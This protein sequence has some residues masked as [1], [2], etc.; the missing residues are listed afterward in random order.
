MTEKATY[1]SLTLQADAH[2]L[3]MERAQ[4]EVARALSELLKAARPLFDDDSF[5]E[6]K[7]QIDKALLGFELVRGSYT[8]LLVNLRGRLSQ[9]RLE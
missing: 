7:S 1:E 2:L 9:N 8:E 4:E 5:A 6:R 3:A